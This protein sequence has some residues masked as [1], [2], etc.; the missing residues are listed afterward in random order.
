MKTRTKILIVILLLQCGCNDSGKI[1]GNDVPNVLGFFDEE[2]SPPTEFDELESLHFKG[3]EWPDYIPADIP[4]LKGDISLVMDSPES[5]I[6]IFY[7]NISEDEIKDYLLELHEL[8]FQLDFLVYVREGFPD[9]S[10]ER[11]KE[12]EYDAVDI[13]KGEYHMRLEF[14]A[15]EAT[16][17]VYTSGFEAEAIAAT[18]PQWPTELNEIIPPPERCELTRVEQTSGSDVGYSIFCNPEDDEVFS[19]YANVLYALGFY[20]DPNIVTVNESDNLRLTDGDT[21]I[22]I[23][24]FFA[25]ELMLT[26][27]KEQSNTA[28]TLEWPQELEG[29]IPP[30]E[31]CEMRSI[32]PG[33]GFM[34]SCKPEDAD[35]LQDYLRM[36]RDLGYVED[37]IFEGLDGQ[38][39]SVTMVKMDTSI[40]LMI[41]P[42]S[43]TIHVK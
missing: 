40:D 17:D 13:T 12:G 23:D 41:S 4:E 31:R 22:Q 8:G 36:L 1:G 5:H 28:P 10:E 29:R 26:I 34:I 18:T 3:G 24:L 37:N 15:G 16:Y 9:N 35:V 14:G 32:I 39:I 21:S 27:H 7:K 25:S 33:A 11:I 42:D 2:N 43:I 38:I 19:D 20:K 6:R 30:P